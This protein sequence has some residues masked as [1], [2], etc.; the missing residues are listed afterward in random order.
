MKI[1]VKGTIWSIGLLVLLMGQ[2]ASVSA[3]PRVSEF[4]PGSGGA[5][6]PNQLVGPVFTSLKIH[7]IQGTGLTVTNPGELVESRRLL[8]AC[9]SA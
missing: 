9:T 8:P 7:E 4:E 3:Q 2:V 6:A 1:E 5:D